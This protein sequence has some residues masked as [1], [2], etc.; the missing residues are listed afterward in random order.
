[1]VGRF[2]G[3]LSLA[4]ALAL[5]GACGPEEEHQRVDLKKRGEIAAPM[6][7]KGLTYAYLPQYSHSVSY[8]RH[9]LLLDYLNKTTGLDIRQIFPGAFDEHVNMVARG[10][11]DISF[12][13]PFVYTQL[14]TQGCAV[15]ARI[16][17][18]S[19]SPDFRSQIITL[20]D[21]ASIQSLEHC[22]G[23]RWIAVDPSSAGG[24]LFAL[25][26]FYDAGLKASDF[27]EIAFAPGP[28]G[29][30]EKVVLAIYAGAYDVGSVRD[31][32]LALLS[33]RIDLDRIRVLDESRSYP[34]WLFAA[35]AGVDK[36]AVRKIADALFA[37]RLDRPEDARILLAAG[38]RGVIP[39]KDQDYDPVRELV[40][41]LGY[42]AVRRE[43]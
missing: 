39:A 41:K 20:K 25:G 35:R 11:I 28:G 36:D 30:Q 34:G 40:A 5:L 33:G 38:M 14:A 19:G 6:P 8:E 4:L 12:V 24:Y 37:L 27:A 7:S 16:I 26:H 3:I 2:G 23:K 43:R 22:R 18:P 31:G 15:F 10:E 13:N 21:N 1:M 9:R 42:T 32:T 17:E 29:K